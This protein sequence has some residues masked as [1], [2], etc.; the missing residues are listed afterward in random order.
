MNAGGVL[1]SSKVE[2]EWV[3]AHFDMLFPHFHI[4]NRIQNLHPGPLPVSMRDK[5]IVVNVASNTVWEFIITLSVTRWPDIVLGLQ[6]KKVFNAIPI[7]IVYRLETQ[8]MP[9]MHMNY[10]FYPSY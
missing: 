6:R 8:G 5:M 7:I 4:E 1:A 9:L 10:P 3:S 2:A